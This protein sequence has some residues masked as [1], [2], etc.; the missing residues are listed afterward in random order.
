M[1][2]PASLKNRVP[3]PLR[4]LAA[5]L[6]PQHSRRSSP[7]VSDLRSHRIGDHGLLDIYWLEVGCD[8]GPAASLYVCD[9]EVMR[10]DCFDGGSAHLHFNQKQ[11][12]AFPNGGGARLYFPPGRVI[13]H[14]ERACFELS[15]NLHYGLALNASRRIRE[16]RISPTA[17]KEAVAF[18]RS[19]M[20]ALLREHEG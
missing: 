12:R 6:L 17:L 16:T 8:R 2:I 19:E 9:D 3:L 1:R 13:D 5:R 15:T 11:S 4:F 20:H 7:N 14:I 10:M 18:M